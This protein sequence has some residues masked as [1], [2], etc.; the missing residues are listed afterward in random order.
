[1]LAV[2]V[3]AAC[4]GEVAPTVGPASFGSASP[5]TTD[6]A[7][8]SDLPTASFEV[9]PPPPSVTPSPTIVD[10]CSGSDANRAFFA[11]AATSMSWPVYC[12]VLGDGWF[13]KDGIY[14]LANGGELEVSYNGPGGAHI[15]IVEGNVCDQVGSDLDVC[16]PRD[17]VI[18]PAAFGDQT[19]EL[20][21]LSNALVIDVDR[22]ANPSW[23][24]SGLGLSEADF[25]AIC[26]AMLR[27]TPG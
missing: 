21:R 18:G 6:T 4:S 3:V 5:G 15:A 20:A 24:A 10:G 26:E 8:A 25:R 7:S 11:E 13:L 14:R 12:A 1:M 17:S 27:V 9:T 2:L 16:A 23:R 19:G 22:G